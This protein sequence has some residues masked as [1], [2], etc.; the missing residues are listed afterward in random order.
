M[1][2]LIGYLLLFIAY[3]LVAVAAL[4]IGAFVGCFIAIYNYIV[5]FFHNV[6]PEK[7]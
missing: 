6:K 1:G 7:I 4:L 3:I 2:E 5:A